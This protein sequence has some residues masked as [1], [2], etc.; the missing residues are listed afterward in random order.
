MAEHIVEDVRLFQVVELVGAADE[1][2]GREA[3][4]GEVVEEHLVGH[5]AR[6]GHDAP[7]GQRRELFVD[8]RE[9]GDALAVQVQRVEPLQKSVAGAAGQHL[10]L[11]LIERHPG[12]MLGRRCSARTP[13]EWSSRGLRLGEGRFAQELPWPLVLLRAP[14]KYGGNEADCQSR[15]FRPRSLAGRGLAKASKVG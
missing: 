4:V 12:A 3:P 11:A 7:A 10:G 1:M 2:A 5:Q 15:R 14:L 13:A 9:I 6:H 8:L